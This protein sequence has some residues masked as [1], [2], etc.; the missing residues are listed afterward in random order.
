M[1]ACRT[2]GQ[3]L[4]RLYL[5][6]MSL[7]RQS[8]RSLDMWRQ[9]GDDSI[10][11]ALPR[12]DDSDDS[13]F[14]ANGWALGT[15]CL[16]TNSELVDTLLLRLELDEDLSE[17]ST[18]RLGSSRLFSIAPVMDCW[19][20]LPCRSGKVED[21]DSVFHVEELME[22]SVTLLVAVA[23]AAGRNLAA[24]RD[25][26]SLDDDSFKTPTFSGYR[27]SISSWSGFRR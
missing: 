12:W 10:E 2:N 22:L 8:L 7:E 21:W 13:V 3:H 26:C 1:A 27:P 18:R 24:G 14:D 9:R 11:D 4:Y 16:N 19:E 5:L 23:A 20:A 17:N 6:Y 15:Y 25:K